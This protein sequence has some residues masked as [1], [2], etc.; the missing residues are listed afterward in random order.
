MIIGLGVLDLK[1][2]RLFCV[3]LSLILLTAC[4]P[5]SQT[6]DGKVRVVA[7]FAPIYAITLT[8]AQGSEGVAVD[9]MAASSAGCLHDYQ[10]TTSDMQA[11]DA[12]ELFLIGGAG[13]EASFLDKITEQYPEL[14]VVDSSAGVPTLAEDCAHEHDHDHA[15][16]GEAVNAHLWLSCDNAALIAQ[17]IAS[18]L[19]EA[20]PANAALYE[21]NAADF[22]E[23]LAV[24]K[25]EYA[26]V[27]EAAQHKKIITFH[28]AFAYLAAEFG[29]EVS[30]VIE[31]EPG[32]APDPRTLSDLIDHAASGDV[33][34][35][36]TEPQ[37]PDD[38][39]RVISEETGVPVRSLDPIVTGEMDA[40]S[41]VTAMQAN[42]QILSDAVK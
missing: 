22:G 25:A 24:L 4:T 9:C 28:E 15:H 29:I 18:A 40:D 20:D 41:F 17:N 23:A 37:Y 10:L 2:K 27:F 38:T 19:S 33:A 14:P 26:P 13:M 31:S 3:L 39:A 34:A 11:V 21:K 16:E 6:E 1:I 35:I 32:S 7:S 30:A 36:F 8:V 42:L 5:T 12:A